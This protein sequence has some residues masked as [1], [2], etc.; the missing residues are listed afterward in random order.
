MLFL[1]L[2][3]SVAHS[4]DNLSVSVEGVDSELQQNILSRLRINVY[5]QDEELSTAKYR[6]CTSWV[7]MI[8]GRR[9]HLSVIIPRKS[10]RL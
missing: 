10:P 7:K 3:T 8:S 4:A 6:G 1:V 9:W 2:I 5:S